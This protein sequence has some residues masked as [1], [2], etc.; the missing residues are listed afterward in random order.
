M[1]DSTSTPKIAI[2]GGGLGGLTSAFY[3]SDPKNPKSYDITIY[4]MGWRLGGKC[5]SGRTHEVGPD[6]Q[7]MNRSLE[8]GIHYLAGCY[9]NAFHML[10]DCFQELNRGADEPLSTCFPDPT[11]VR[12]PVFQP[13]RN[14]AGGD[15][16][17]TFSFMEEVEKDVWKS[18]DFA[19]PELSGTVPGNRSRKGDKGPTIWALLLLLLA[20]LKDR[21]DVVHAD[22]SS[23]LFGKD[24]KFIP[25][26]V[27]FAIRVLRNLDAVITDPRNA[28]DL[29]F[30]IAKNFPD[31][32]VTRRAR[33]SIL[34]LL[35]RIEEDSEKIADEAKLDDSERRHFLIEVRFAT[36]IARGILKEGAFL[37]G[38]DCLDQYEFTDWMKK[39]GAPDM[40]TD[41]ALMRALYAVPL[42]YNPDDDQ[43]KKLSAG[44]AVRFSLRL[45]LDYRGAFVWKMQAGMGEAVITPLYEA[46]KARGVKF[47]YFHKVEKLGL[48]G[49]N[50]GTISIRQ[51]VDLK[52]G[53]AIEDYDPL[54]P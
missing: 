8:H 18:W 43:Q 22:D 47:K 51:Q 46:L 38:F 37:K 1:S 30:D 28:A 26:V 41:S 29:A 2:L 48:D 19:M 40:V 49:R 11:G 53:V 54:V 31:A 52:D 13:L 14:D 35:G 15:K 17:A 36:A 32:P 12:D 27:R 21:V 4:Q 25:R 23:I 24:G 45:F 33:R 39:H 42:A 16:K 34:W 44:V 3:L 9:E 7:V 20:W 6:G 10:D 5:A 50:I